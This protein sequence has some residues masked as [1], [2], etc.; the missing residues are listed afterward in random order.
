MATLVILLIIFFAIWLA[1]PWIRRRIHQ[2]MLNKAEDMFRQA[3]GM[4]PREKKK[5]RRTADNAQAQAENNR[6]NY[7]YNYGY[8]YEDESIIPKEYAEDVEYT[9]YKDYSSETVINRTDDTVRVEQQEQVSD[10]EYIEIKE[11]KDGAR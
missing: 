6:R 1:M 5:K 4:P 7:G 11:K 2:I 9:E 3:A 10:V 8:G